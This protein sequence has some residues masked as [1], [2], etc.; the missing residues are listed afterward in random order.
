MDSEILLKVNKSVLAANKIAVVLPEKLT[1]DTVCAGVALQQQLTLDGKDVS[2]FS[3]CKNLPQLEFISH[4]I[5][6]FSSFGSGNE[7]TI[8]VSGQR[9][10]PKQLRY[11]KNHDDLLIYV[12][13]ESGTEEKQFVKEDIEVLPAVSSFDLLIILGAET[14]E[15][16]GALYDQ[17]PEIFFD[18]PKLTINN[19]INQE[20]FASLTWV[21]VDSPSLCQ[22]LTKW[23]MQNPETLKNDLVA[24]SLLAGIIS[25]TQ[26]FNDPKTTPNS[27]IFAA[28]LVANGARREDIIKYL[29]KTKPFNLLQ[30]WGRA[31]ARIK[32]F[33]KD[34]ILYTMLTAQDFIKTQT[35]KDLLPQVL[36]E[37]ISMAN[38]YKLII[39]AAEL[40]NG[41]EL[42]FAAPPHIKIKQIAKSIDPT[43]SGQVEPLLAN[44]QYLSLNLPNFKLEDL[45]S[46]VSTLGTSGI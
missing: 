1:I 28:K 15:S 40:S 32:T 33:Q 29:F 7:L 11:E 45:E 31:L 2:L 9:V 22:Q 43:F 18:T 44:Y 42:L 36:S 46:T 34:T 38:N 13:P 20:Y 35:N 12:T 3:S 14:L 26:S 24:T 8:K 5:K 16:L 4:P 21:E 17:K 30:L 39:L 6:I 41:V 23:F 27:L 37:I 10:K 19:S 25:A